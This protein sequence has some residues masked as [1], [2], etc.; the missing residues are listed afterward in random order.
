MV[1]APS[2][3]FVYGSNRGH[4][5][6]AIFAID[7]TTGRLTPRGH[8]PTQGRTPRNFNIDPS[9]RFLY[10]ANQDSDSLVA[11]RIDERSGGLVPTGQVVRVGSPSCVVFRHAL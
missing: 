2:G 9:G 6:V 5:S 10:A 1:V 7:Q 4:D 8:E 3:Q 11:F